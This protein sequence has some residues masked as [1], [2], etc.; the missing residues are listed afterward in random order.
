METEKFQSGFELSTPDDK[1]YGV[2]AVGPA[3]LTYKDSEL[4]RV[5]IPTY[6][7]RTEPIGDVI[8]AVA[9]S[10]YGDRFYPDRKSTR[11]NSSH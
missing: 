11:L 10:I 7:I 4:G 6:Q 1:E 2:Y 8:N 9:A 5:Y 3:V